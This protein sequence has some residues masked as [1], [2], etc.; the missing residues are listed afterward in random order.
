MTKPEKKVYNNEL[1]TNAFI[2]TPCLLSFQYTNNNLLYTMV[3][4]MII[5]KKFS[6]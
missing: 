3:K 5:S 2:T 1:K 4:F 6:Y